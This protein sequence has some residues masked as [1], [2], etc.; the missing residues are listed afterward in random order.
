VL[1]AGPLL[2][3]AYARAPVPR[4]PRALVA[5][6]ALCA[7]ATWTVWGP[8]RETAAVAG[9]DATSAAYYAPVKSFFARRGPVRVEVPL[10][11]SHWEAALL[12]PSVPLA[13]GW[14]KQLDER[15]DA[16]LLGNGLSPASY[17]AWLR[18]QA[19]GWV[20]LPDARLDPSSAREGRLLRAGLPYLRQVASS[21][22]WRIY[23]VIGATPLMSGPGRL[24]SLAGDGF[25]LTAARSGRFVVRAHYS[26][27]LRITHGAGCVSEA[28]GGW[29]AI[30]VDAPGPVR[31][32]A[33]FS[34][35]RA[36][37]AS[38][39]CTSKRP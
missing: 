29:T 7:A 38:P 1:L 22:H 23:R 35:G 3:C 2:L 21:T 17:Y 28:P 15:Y 19:V 32:A 9:G 6:L 10:T 18:R 5:A 36:F 14:E 37:S 31:V 34:I 12:A 27:Y 8:V 11:R 24:T 39:A 25:S 16:E 13:R 30:R 20:A 4:G 26:R 33:R